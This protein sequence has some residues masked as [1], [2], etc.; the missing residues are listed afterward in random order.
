M[1]K[2]LW[3]DRYSLMACKAIYE[4]ASNLSYELGSQPINNDME[5]LQLRMVQLLRKECFHV[6]YYWACYLEEWKAVKNTSY[7]KMG[8][9]RYLA[10]YHSAMSTIDFITFPTSF[11]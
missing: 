5:A 11:F 2:L 8:V 7:N 10:K 9:I 4:V 6:M 3:L 1:I